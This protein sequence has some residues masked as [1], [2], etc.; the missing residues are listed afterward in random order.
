VIP[1]LMRGLITI[2]A[3][4]AGGGT[5]MGETGAFAWVVWITCGCPRSPLERQRVH[6]SYGIGSP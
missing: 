1:R 4:R 6:A 2:L 5:T 3:K